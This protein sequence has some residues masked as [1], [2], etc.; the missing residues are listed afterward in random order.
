MNNNFVAFMFWGETWKPP[1]QLTPY[2]QNITGN[3]KPGKYRVMDGKLV[4]IIGNLP[5][6]C[7]EAKLKDTCPLNR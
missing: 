3:F 5:L 7:V 1:I 6:E 4:P 2:E